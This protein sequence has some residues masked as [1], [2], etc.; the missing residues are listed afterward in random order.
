LIDIP[1]PSAVEIVE[2]HRIRY[3]YLVIAVGSV[4]NDFGVPGVKD[5]SNAAEA[6]ATTM[7]NDRQ[8]H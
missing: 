2:R 1:G 6:G 4:S 3:H 5:D 7:A 8:S